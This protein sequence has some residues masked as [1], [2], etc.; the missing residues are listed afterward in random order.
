M[1]D[2][3]V[4][5]AS[6][7]HLITSHPQILVVTSLI[8]GIIPLPLIVLLRIHSERNQNREALIRIAPEE[9]GVSI[10]SN[11]TLSP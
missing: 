2:A 4:L 6:V 11:K 9:V 1:I 5:P 8:D 3:M 10:S 7:L